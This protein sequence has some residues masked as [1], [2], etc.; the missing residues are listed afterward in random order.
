[1]Q[2]LA[3]RD[4]AQHLLS[5]FPN[6][7][8]TLEDYLTRRNALQDLRWST[9]PLLP[10][11]ERLVKHLHTHN[12]PMVVATGSRRRNLEMKSVNLRHVFNL[13]GSRILC[14]DDWISEHGWGKREVIHS[15]DVARPVIEPGRG[16]PCPD[17]FLVAARE[18]LGKAVG[19][20]EIEMATEA[21]RTERHKG[22]VFEDAI[23]GVHAGKRAGMNGKCIRFGFVALSKK[24]SCMGT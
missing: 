17:L 16:K 6:I 20:S 1:M 4:A 18:V 19:Q 14:A 15:G 10:G 5:F 21:E 12:I 13:F 23:P 24:Y 9:V 8:L 11:V 3:E 2:I 22:L 7:S